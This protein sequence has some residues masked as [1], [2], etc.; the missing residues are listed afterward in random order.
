MLS[1]RLFL[2][3]TVPALLV[4]MGVLP[5]AGRSAPFPGEYVRLFQKTPDPPTPVKPPKIHEL[6]PLQP[7]PAP[8]VPT[9]DP[10]LPIPLST[11]RFRWFEVKDYTGSVTWDTDNADIIQVIESIKADTDVIGRVEG[12]EKAARYS[13]PA[14]AGIVTTAGKQGLATLRAYGVVDGRAKRLDTITILVGPQ[15]PPVPPGPTPP[16]PI[17]PGPTPGPA[18]IPDAGF[19]VLIVYESSAI[20][21]AQANVINSTIMRKY[22]DGKC[23]KGPDGKTTEYRILDKDTVMSNESSLWQKAM[24]R[25]HPNLPWIIISNGRTG[26]EEPLPTTIDATMALI[27]KYAEG[28]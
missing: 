12:T 13:V 8:V 26:T 10:S 9:V 17:P 28:N 25:P 6:T 11:D 4:V 20:T 22:L 16:G 27:K 23:V 1:R 18:P 2:M 5:A 24:Q 15:P 21:A 7:A 19:R 3:L 14:N